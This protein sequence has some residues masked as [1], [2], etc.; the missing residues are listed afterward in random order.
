M[1]DAYSLKARIYPTILALLPILIIVVFFSI[2][3]ESI[4]HSLSSLGLV[5]VL[6]Y[7]LS[8]LGRDQGKKKESELWKS[9][10]GSPTTQLLR[11]TDHSIDKYTKE[12]YHTKM[13]Q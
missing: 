8:Q 5:A 6:G 11:L 4:I 12:R 1:I 13:K 9:W 10:G 7:L 2:Q 3:F